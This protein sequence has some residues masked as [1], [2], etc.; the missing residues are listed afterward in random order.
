[1]S[2]AQFLAGLSLGLTVLVI[3]ALALMFAGLM[4]SRKGDLP[5]LKRLLKVELAI[6]PVLVVGYAASGTLTRNPLDI[7]LAMLWA[8]NFIMTRRRLS[9]LPK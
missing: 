7:L 4:A 8:L 5:R 3:A 6:F 2:Q 9:G 1:M